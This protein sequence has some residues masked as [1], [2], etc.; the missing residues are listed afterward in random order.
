MTHCCPPVLPR[1]SVSTNLR[2]APC[3]CWAG[4]SF[5]QGFPLPVRPRLGSTSSGWEIRA[6]CRP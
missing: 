1:G 3:R 4:T 5:A 2:P 6:A